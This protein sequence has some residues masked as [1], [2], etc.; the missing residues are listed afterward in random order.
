MS[1]KN[2]RSTAQQ[3]VSLL[4]E[5]YANAIVKNGYLDP[6]SIKTVLIKD[7]VASKKYNK[8]VDWS[9]VFDT[10]YSIFR[11]FTAD[12][13]R[14]DSLS[15][16]EV[17]QLS[18]NADS[19]LAS[20]PLEY[21]FLL[22][23]P[24][25]API[26]KNVRI[27]N[28]IS[29]VRLDESDVERYKTANPEPKPGSRGALAS[30]LLTIQSMENQVKVPEP[31]TIYLKVSCHGYVGDNESTVFEQDPIYI[32]KV[33]FSLNLAL[34]NLQRDRSPKKLGIEQFARYAFRAYM[35]SG[36]FVSSLSRPDDEARLINRYTF[37][38][39]TEEQILQ[40]AKRMTSL[41]TAQ[42]YSGIEKL[43][44]QIVNSLFWYFETC[45]TDNPNLKTVFFT[46]VFDSF[47]D[48][49]DKGKD[50]ARMIAIEASTTAQQQDIA[51]AELDR[52]YQSRNE[53]IHG[54]RAL[55][56]YQ[57]D[58]KQKNETQR[59]LVEIS[60]TNFYNRYLTSKLNRY[61]RSLGTSKSVS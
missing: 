36:R 35:K 43:R 61:D 52:L 37:N 2:T 48:Q 1:V 11:D 8:I 19:Y 23:L 25:D 18:K 31:G 57:I 51:R 29:I 3:P 55:L 22:P 30:L 49:E 12:K 21:H 13:E 53:I 34:G 58:G 6:Y 33:W 15:E 16:Q 44:N 5:I 47:F 56:D 10:I 27:T 7:I 39:T 38:E 28:K 45:K 24:V 20:L 59:A 40:A 41:M 26:T 14:T 60:A 50:K 54:E 4:K 9:C 42:N 32:Y 17:K 46:S